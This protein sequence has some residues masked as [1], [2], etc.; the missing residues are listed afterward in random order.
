MKVRKIVVGGQAGAD[1]GGLIAGQLL[2]LET[3]GTAPPNF[4]TE[5]G[6]CL[7]LRDTYG[8]VEGGYDRRVYPK[9][10]RR[11]IEDSDGTL[12]M[13]NTSSPGS[14]LTLRLCQELGKPR[15]ENPTPSELKAW[16]DTN[17]VEVLNVAGNRESRTPG[18]EKVTT[19]L[20]CSVLE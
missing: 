14:R 10:T 8:L 9:R 12:L 2:K 20:L 7:E 4:M 18:I 19:S 16:L 1:R 15:I 5:L 11:N 6:T 13:G 3:G 17:D